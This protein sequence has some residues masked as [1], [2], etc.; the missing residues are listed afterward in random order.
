ME[1]IKANILKAISEEHISV[2]RF[3][4]SCYGETALDE[5]F[6]S[7]MVQKITNGM[8]RWA[9]ARK[10][11][12]NALSGLISTATDHQKSIENNYSV[13][14]G[15]IN[16]NRYEISIADAKKYEHEITTL[17]FFIGF[18]PAERSELFAKLTSL[19]KF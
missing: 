2:F 8:D 13:D 11:M 6:E 14:S 7:K 5:S 17:T 9:D 3:V 16:S 18:T 12:H 1:I 19:I 4:Q 10:D 15:W